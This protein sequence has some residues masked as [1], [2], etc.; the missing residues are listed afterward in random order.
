MH[1][2]TAPKKKN[3]YKKWSW[4]QAMSLRGLMYLQSST[5][6]PSSLPTDKYIFPHVVPITQ[7]LDALIDT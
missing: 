1:V 7:L 2:H 3:V 5:F 6:S 4:V